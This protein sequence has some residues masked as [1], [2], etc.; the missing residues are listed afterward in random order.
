METSAMARIAM[1]IITSMR[2]KPFA[3]FSFMPLSIIWECI[4]RNH[5]W[6]Y[7][8]IYRKYP[9]RQERDLSLSSFCLLHTPDGLLRENRYYSFQNKALPPPLMF[10]DYF[11]LRC[12]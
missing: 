2:V 5:S 3:F 1:A 4:A 10:F 9:S 7:Q 11:R 6:K 12:P 8:H